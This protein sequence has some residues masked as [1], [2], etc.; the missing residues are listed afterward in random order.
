MKKIAIADLKIT[1]QA[2]QLVQ[3]AL[4]SNRLTYGPITEKFESEFAKIHNRKFA[5]FMNSGT[6][7]LQVGLH[8]LKEYYKW[9]D[10]DEVLVPTITFVA[11]SNV[12]IQN[13]LKPV[14]VDVDP[15]YY[16]IDS[17]QIEKHITKR[18]RAIMPVHLFGQSCDM[19]SI[20]QIAKK[21]N[22]RVI[23]DSCESLFTKYKGKPVGS[24]GDVS[25]YSTYVAHFIVTGVG[26]LACTNNDNLAILMRSLMFHGR[27]N[28]YLKI[29]DDDTGN[30]KRLLDITS[31]RFQFEHVGY[32]YRVTEMESALGLIELKKWKTIIIRRQR[33]AD[34]LTKNLSRFS[35]YLQ[36]P[37]IR[38]ETEHGFMLYPIVIK[39]NEVN[40]EKLI[41]YLETHGIETRYLMP[42]LNQPVY[43]KLFGNNLEQKYPTA[44][45]LNK[46]GFIIGCH[47]YLN[48]SDLR[49]IVKVFTNFFERN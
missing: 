40:R 3:K 5:L 33:N 11:S 31:K 26:G 25:C 12:I 19:D 24:L 20:M 37:K 16:E 44:K 18:T 10:G 21:Y 38:P 7:A 14:F 41:V 45:Y 30:K 29:E 27:N 34:F 43:K 35:E 49:Y 6:S 36:L 8:A 15:N 23:E 48:Y 46:N 22:L 1:K 13:N 47:H 42:L 4:N 9:K 28:I 32:N 2:K 39:N 17:H